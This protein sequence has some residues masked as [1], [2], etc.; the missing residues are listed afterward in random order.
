MEVPQTRD[1]NGILK[2]DINDTSANQSMSRSLS[3]TPGGVFGST[4]SSPM[5]MPRRRLFDWSPVARAQASIAQEF[6]AQSSVAQSMIPKGHPIL[7]KGGGMSTVVV[8]YTNS[9][10]FKNVY[11]GRG[12]LEPSKLLQGMALGR[13][14]S[15]GQS[16]LNSGGGLSGMSLF[17]MEHYNPIDTTDTTYNAI[18]G[19]EEKHGGDDEEKGTNPATP[20][21]STDLGTTIELTQEDMRKQIE[22]ILKANSEV[23]RLHELAQAKIKA[24]IEKRHKYLETKKLKREALAVK[25]A[26]RDAKKAASTEPV[27]ND[28]DSDDSGNDSVVSSDDTDEEKGTNPSAHELTQEARL[29]QIQEMINNLQTPA[30]LKRAA[31]KAKVVASAKPAPT[32]PAPTTPDDAEPLVQISLIDRIINNSSNLDKSFQ[33]KSGDK[34]WVIVMENGDVKSGNIAKMKTALNKVG[35]TPKM[36]AGLMEVKKFEKHKLGQAYHISKSMLIRAL[37][38][39]D[40]KLNDLAKTDKWDDDMAVKL[41]MLDF[42]DVPDKDP[43]AKLVQKSHGKKGKKPKKT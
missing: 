32:T 23:Q 14:M 24:D 3:S 7:A 21:S 20:T 36:T 13:G 11:K 41:M 42:P 1:A 28:D 19:E 6:V 37:D 40:V 16:I 10:S 8:Q 35:I 43:V 31:R 26:E 12:S 33:S 22:D 5:I 29:K 39:T 15:K 25:K 27:T 34:T 17:K 30:K 9:R 2:I 4:Q 38:I 18:G